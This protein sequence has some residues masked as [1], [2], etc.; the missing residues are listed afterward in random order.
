MSPPTIHHPTTLAEA[1]ELL[2]RYDG[3]ARV[4]AGSTALTLMIHQ[5]LIDP[6]ALISLGRVPGL[7]GLTTGPDGLALGA[8]VTHRQV[9]R[10]EVVRAAAPVLTQAFA[11][12]ANVRV[13]NA[14]TVGGV[15]AEADYA[16]DPP[17]AFR[18]LD[19]T[20]HATGPA[21]ERAIP[22]ADFF[23]G[24]YETSLAS[25]EILV[26]VTV[27]PPVAGT[28]S[29][30]LRYTTRSSEDRPCVGVAALVRLD[31][32]GVCEELRVAVGAATEIPARFPDLEAAASG[33]PVQEAAQL[34]ADG[35]A[36]RIDPLDDLRGS[37]W[38]RTEM[39]RVW[40]RR[41]VVAAAKGTAAPATA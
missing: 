25:D 21:G 5:R 40:V 8:L 13:R 29:A 38:Y 24:F 27:P 10:S 28:S 26:R 4:L 41:T 18:A 9:E 30:Y 22:I 23:H 1:V 35:Y 39:I 2:Q 11:V 37:S 20:V 12:V 19:A 31:G 3:E 32:D 34:L 15:L 14:A 16:S 36:S 17:T 33:R 7:N 6:P